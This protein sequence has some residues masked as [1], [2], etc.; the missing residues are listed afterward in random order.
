MLMR[1]ARVVGLIVGW[2]GISPSKAAEL[3]YPP[4]LPGGTTVV[5]LSTP[6]FLRS[7]AKLV[8][9]QGADAPRS[10]ADTPRSPVVIAKTP[11]RVDFLYY[12][13]QDYPGRPWSAWGDSL[14]A[15]GQYYSSI[16]DHG[17]P[18]G[19]AF[20]YEYDPETK[21]IRCLVNV[22]ETLKLPEGHYTPGKIHSRIDLGSDGWLY[23]ATHRGST[24]VTTDKHHYE[25]DWIIRHH[26]RDKKTEIVAHGPA[27]KQCIPTSVLDAQRMIFYGGTAAAD[28]RD[29]RVT[30]F[31]FDLK[32]RKLLHSE[33]DGPYR[34]FLF[35]KST[36]RVYFT[37]DDDQ[38]LR[39]YDPGAGSSARLDVR[40]GLRAATEETPEGCVYTVCRQG[41][42]WR[43]HAK[44]EKAEQLGSAAVGTENYIATLDADPTGRYL[45][46]VP[47]AHGGGYRDG[48][49][50]VQYDVRTKA[51][52]VLAFLYPALQKEVGYAP[53]GTYSLSV[54]ARGERLYIT[55]NGNR[56]GSDDRGRLNFDTCALTVV[57]IPE[58][59][60]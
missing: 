52:K 9:H 7:E 4:Q 29:A 33:L 11:P 22:R 27:G 18:G 16:G 59:E 10:P 49:P 57:H 45:Y 47:G 12:P 46:Y 30:F 60:R 43:F 34:Y 55:W 19:N 15:N 24:R 21:T 1:L 56:G 6:A 39:R 32:A 14:A 5:T 51:R 13:K 54:D 36:G 25:G 17:A 8:T 3:T 20:V 41:M 2:I 58:S 28:Y 42:L 48:T 37:P 31:A 35:A 23:F 38:P 50:I 44:T 26:P 53:I 40:L